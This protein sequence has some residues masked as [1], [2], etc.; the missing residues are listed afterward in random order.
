[1]PYAPENNRPA[2]SRTAQTSRGSAA[3]RN[4]E[5]NARTRRKSTA[6]RVIPW[7]AF[8]CLFCL[9][10]FIAVLFIK[11]KYV[12]K[13]D[14]EEL[15]KTLD[16]GAFFEGITVNGVDIG[17]M[18]YDEARAALL[19]SVTEGIQSINI[20]VVHGTS[21]WVLTAADLGAVST[22]DATLSE[23]MLLGR[24]ESQAE[25]TATLE[26]L[27]AFGKAYTVGYTCT[28]NALGKTVEE[29]GAGM[30]TQPVEPYAESD[31]WATEPTFIYHEGI[32]GHTLDKPAL[33]QQIKACLAS[34]DYT[35]TLRPELVVAKPQHDIAWIKQNTQL[36]ASWQT[37]FGSSSSLRNA[38]RVGNIQKA[39]TILNGACVQVGEEF[40]FNAFIGPR[41]E[42][43][44][45]PLAPGI[46]NGNS[47]EMQAGGGICQ[48]STTLY[49]AL[50]CCGEQI[51]ITERFHHS[52]PSS[53]ADYGLDSTV[54][55]SA[56]SGKSLN[57]I[58][59]TGAPLYIFAKCDQENKLM[60]IY[61]YGEPLPAGVSYKTRGEVIET[62]EPGEPVVTENPAWPTG[63]EETTVKSRKGYKAEAYL[64][65]YANGE[66]KNGKLLYTDSYRAVTAQIT[67]GTGDPALPKPTQADS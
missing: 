5:R 50:L 52:W 58:N 42:A 18:H 47:Y 45:W 15:A 29:I 7:L 67:R 28:E 41:T 9:V 10:A 65:E 22:L 2:N 40:N 34:G 8:L 44:G 1:M 55:G 4:T 60:N 30:G 23:A 43:G 38:N 25:N 3:R 63:Y 62:I 51:E 36:R 56:E 24:N 54:T 6:R 19:P 53:Y 20:R 57:F 64:D 27:K 46:V 14:A 66:F 26:N 39:T 49:N 12:N 35:A 31:S 61:I 33:M 37:D 11:S 17:G 21:L 59:N 16:T 32:D 13:P 48:V